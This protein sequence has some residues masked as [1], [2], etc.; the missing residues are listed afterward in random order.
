MGIP[1]AG[2]S[3]VASGYTR[4][5]Y[6]RLNRDERGGSLRALAAE[7]DAQLDSGLR[8]A[9][10]DNTYLS[11]E[12]RSRVIEGPADGRRLAHIL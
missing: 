6:T 8:R 4:R 5:G 2:K 1:G 7:L 12:A 11:R 9:V 3:R 10:L